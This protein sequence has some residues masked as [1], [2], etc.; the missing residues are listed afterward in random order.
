MRR[1]SD[2][3]RVNLSIPLN[4]MTRVFLMC[5][6]PKKTATLF[7]YMTESEHLRVEKELRREC[8]PNRQPTPLDAP[9][10]YLLQPPPPHQKNKVYLRRQRLR[11]VGGN[12][13]VG[14]GGGRWSTLTQHPGRVKC[15]FKQD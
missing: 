1:A 6:W 5:V 10:R 13:G 14:G 3:H 4:Y 9:R 11:G 12:W 15:V 2:V 8:E 7:S